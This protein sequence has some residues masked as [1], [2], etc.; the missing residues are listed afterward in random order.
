MQRE[1]NSYDTFGLFCLPLSSS[2][3]VQ[4][5]KKN[6]QNEQRDDFGELD[7]KRT[8]KEWY[9]NT[10]TPLD[11]HQQYQQQKQQQK[12]SDNDVLFH[13]LN[14]LKHEPSVCMMFDADRAKI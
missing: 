3:C 1:H 2:H 6:A 9:Y 4:G 12:R 13:G 5:Q 11:K 10:H 14:Q 7:N 8:W